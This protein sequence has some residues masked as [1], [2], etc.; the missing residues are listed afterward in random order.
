MKYSSFTSYSVLSFRREG[1]EDGAKPSETRMP[2][3]IIVKKA[4]G[5]HNSII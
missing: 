5:H 1:T 3:S 4:A 2:T